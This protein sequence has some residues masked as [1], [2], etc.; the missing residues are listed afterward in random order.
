MP[1]AADYLILKRRAQEEDRMVYDALT[2]D[3]FKVS[4]NAEWEIKTLGMIENLQA[5]R[6]FHGIRQADEAAL[7]SRRRRL[8]EMLGE[9]QARFSEQLAALDESPSERKARMES[10]AAELKEKRENERLAYVRQQYERQWRMACDP[11]REQES[12]EILKATNAARA[13][14]IGEK[15]KQL[16]LEEQENR[17]FDELWEKDR[18]A[19]LGREEAEEDARKTMDFEHKLVL[20]QQVSELHGFRNAETDMATTEAALMRQQWDVEREEAKKVEAM[21]YEVL[22]KAND[23]LHEFNKHKRLQLAESVAAERKADA[24]RLAAQLALEA[25][26]NEREAAARES[27]QH[28]TRRFAEHIMQQKRAIAMQE[29][30]QEVARKAEQDK[31]WDKRLAVWGR[32]QEARENLMAQVLNERKQQVEVKLQA[33]LVDK[34]NQAEARRR[35]E[36]ELSHVNAIEQD[37]TNQMKD[38]R[39]MHRSLLENQIKDKAFKRAAGEFNKA[40]ER[41]AAERAEAAYQMMLTDQMNK[42]STTMNKFAQNN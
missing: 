27:M 37:K 23:E 19:K 36:A 8:A 34:Q 7:N 39:M 24:E 2:K 29:G 20:D 38:I 3:N 14:Q 18:L 13:Y 40:Q 1:P 10:R 42:T 26:E 6:R 21:R 30:E 11:L 35:L 4:A 5:Q 12:K 16:E 41:M 9:E 15:M 25:H 28:E 32:E 17:A 22:M 31:A 33:T